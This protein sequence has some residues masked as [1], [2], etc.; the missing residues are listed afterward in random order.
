[1]RPSIA[2]WPC[3]SGDASPA[4]LVVLKHD[5]EEVRQFV[6]EGDLSA[7]EALYYVVPEAIHAVPVLLYWLKYTRHAS[8]SVD[9][10][11]S[12]VAGFFE[13]WED[14]CRTPLQLSQREL[15]WI[16]STAPKSVRDTVPSLANVCECLSLAYIQTTQSL[17]CSNGLYS[18]YRPD[19]QARPWWTAAPPNLKVVEEGLTRL[20]AYS[21]GY[22]ALAP[23]LHSVSNVEQLVRRLGEGQMQPALDAA[24]SCC[25][26]AADFDLGAGQAAAAVLLF[27]RALDLFLQARCFENGLIRKT[28]RGLEFADTEQNTVSVLQC[29][30]RLVD[31]QIYR[32]KQRVREMI[33]KCNEIRNNLVLT[34]SLFGAT[35]A[36][37]ARYRQSVLSILEEVDASAARRVTEWIRDEHETWQMKPSVL[38]AFESD[39][40]A[41]IVKV[42]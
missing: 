33:W 42:E 16:I 24:A 19:A 12:D 37:A 13:R 29:Y 21:K 38:F 1:M 6:L 25:L 14:I 23:I 32:R 39:L 22:P 41:C 8:H 15:E 17:L 11:E 2:G 28:G 31:R 4:V 34:H 10:S 26:K 9:C 30:T 3:S 20:R 40:D 35:Q 5:L 27:H 7:P 18:D 36:Y